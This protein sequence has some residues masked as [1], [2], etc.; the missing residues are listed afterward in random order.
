M[1]ASELKINPTKIQEL[2]VKFLNKGC[3]IVW[4]SFLLLIHEQA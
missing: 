1:H 3:L 2:P 4:E